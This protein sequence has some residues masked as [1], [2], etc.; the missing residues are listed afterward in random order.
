MGGH[1]GYLEEKADAS[2]G[3]GLL[4]AS[5][6]PDE[7]RRLDEIKKKHEFACLLSPRVSV[8][9]GKLHCQGDLALLG[10]SA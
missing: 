5:G 10:Y 2:S 6:R 1:C 7:T 8:S 9:F 3:G 4:N